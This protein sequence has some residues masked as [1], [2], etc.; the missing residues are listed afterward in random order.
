MRAHSHRPG[1]PC[2]PGRWTPAVGGKERPGISRARAYCAIRGGACQPD[3]WTPLWPRYIMMRSSARYIVRPGHK[4]SL[5]PARPG[6]GAERVE[7]WQ[8]TEQAA[9][10]AGPWCRSS[11]QRSALSAHR[12]TTS[13]YQMSRR[14]AHLVGRHGAGCIS[15]GV[16]VE[17]L[18]YLA[19]ELAVRL[20]PHPQVDGKG[21]VG[22]VR[23]A[24]QDDGVFFV[25]QGRM[26]Q[27]DRMGWR[28]GKQEQDDRQE[29]QRDDQQGRM[30]GGTRTAA[31]KSGLA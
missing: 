1:G 31:P 25:L 7:Q 6:S 17:V 28:P 20:A 14:L 3:R 13:C 5:G 8:P 4:R 18:E 26:Y 29:R 19:V 2:Q 27:Q 9:S 24:V 10:G 22:A 15:A 23:H 11:A 12:I 21:A 16:G 30:E